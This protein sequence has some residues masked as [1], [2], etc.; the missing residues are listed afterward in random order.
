M[1]LAAV[2][3]RR[4]VPLFHAVSRLRTSVGRAGDD[5]SLMAAE[6]EMHA[7]A[8]LISRSY[9]VGRSVSERKSAAPELCRRRIRRLKAH[10]HEQLGTCLTLDGLAE[11]AEMTVHHFL[12]AF[13]RAF[14][15]TPA[16]YVMHQ[17][18]RRAQHELVST[19]KDI[20]T[21]A[22]DC[23]FSSHSH[24]TSTFTRLVGEAPSH[25]RRE[26]QHAPAGAGRMIS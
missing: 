10:V 22:L 12:V 7:V 13:R 16:Q 20:T 21:I 4:D 2:A 14:A 26:M 5:A 15:T 1:D 23:G 8:R 17:R 24:L 6:Q 19:R 3:A 18:L 9:G 25:Y 11:L